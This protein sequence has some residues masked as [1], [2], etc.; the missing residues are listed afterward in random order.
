M[1]S[2]FI[3]HL[4]SLQIL[5]EL[6]N[7]QTGE[8]FRA[9]YEYQA[10]GKEPHDFWLKIAFAPFK[11]QFERDLVKYQTICDRNKK[12]AVKGG[13]PKKQNNRK[14]PVG[15][16]G[17]DLHPEN[18]DSDSDSDSENNINILF[19]IFWETYDKKIDRAKCLKVWDKLSKD[20]KINLQ[21][22]IELA[23]VYVNS[24]PDIKFRKNPLTWLNGK[25]WEDE[26]KI[27]KQTEYIPTL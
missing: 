1:K 6:S 20:K 22:V 17:S 14:N 26:V 5:N 4:D 13:R 8:L 25:C 23:S 7:E 24:T 16:F 3:L 12:N 18:L 19:N 15:L 9:I 10:T 27:S 2:S 21:T 11:A